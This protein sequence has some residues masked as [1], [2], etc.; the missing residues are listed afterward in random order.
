MANEPAGGSVGFGAVVSS[1]FG[2]DAGKRP[3]SAQ[4]RMPGRGGVLHDLYWP[5]LVPAMLLVAL[6]LVVVWSASLTNAN[7]SLPRQAIGAILGFAAATFIWRYDYRQLSNMSTALLVL[8]IALMLLPRVPFLSYEGG[9]GMTGWVQFG[10]LR[11]QPSEVGKLVTIFLMA[12]LGAQFNGRIKELRDYVKLCATLLV[13]FVCILAQ[14]D[15]GTGLIILV[16]GAAVIICSG[17]RRSWVLVTLVLV[18]IGAALIVT[19]SLNFNFPLKQYQVNRL[20]VFVNPEADTSDAGYNLLQAKIAVG[21]GGLFGKGVGNATQAGGGFLPESHTDFVFA[22][23]AEEFG[24]VGSIVLLGLY[25]WLFFSTIA[26][27]QRIEAPFSKLVLAG[28]VAMWSYQVL[29][30]IGMCI[31]IM[32]IT[33]IP[34][35]FI[36]YGASSMVVQVASVGIVQSVWFHRTKSA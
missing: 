30:N 6:G 33:G 1:M 14:P 12:S 28:V 23:L 31:G 34:L 18:V 19:C 10:P 11:F 36:S 35:P 15:L 32:P 3:G 22:L 5:A 13:P 24:F 2:G 9:L 26:L 4:A 7:A 16:L 8:D 17:A 27:A 25:G 21:S 20:L 29:Q